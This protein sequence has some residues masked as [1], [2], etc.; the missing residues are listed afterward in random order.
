MFL[1]YGNEPNEIIIN[2]D[3]PIVSLCIH[4]HI[5]IQSVF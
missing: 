2:N 3:S 1:Y 4:I 5:H